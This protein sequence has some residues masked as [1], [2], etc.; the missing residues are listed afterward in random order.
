MRDVIQEMPLTHLDSKKRWVNMQTSMEMMHQM[1]DASQQS[2]PRIVD[3]A[4]Q[5]GVS[6][7]TVDRV[8]NGRPGV[9]KKTVD[10]VREAERWLAQTGGRPTVVAPPPIG[11]VLD[12]LLAGGKGFANEI[13]MHEFKKAGRA[14]G[15]D[16]RARFV[17]RASVA[18][19]R[20]ELEEC[21]KTRSDGVIVQ[22]IEHLAVRDAMLELADS[23]VPIVCALT[24][25]PGIE[26]LGYSGLD[27]R[28]AGR[29]AGLLL[30]HLCGRR[31]EVAIF[32]SD[33]LYRSHE[34][35]ESGVRNL[36]RSD[37]PD[38]AT[39][40][41]VNTM[42]NPETCYKKTLDLI[43]RHPGLAG[44]CNLGGGNR[45][46]EKAAIEAGRSQDLAYVAFNLTPLTRKSLMDGTIKGVVHQDMGKISRNAIDLIC[47]HHRGERATSGYV[48]A[49]IIMRENIRDIGYGGG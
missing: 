40:E 44:I 43:E 27:N 37:F 21:R 36:L 22:P 12:I 16:L 8:M 9:K 13:L 19:L 46:I 39:L 11:L 18:S 6:T 42:D 41:S 17:E 30:G 28:A 7:A 47:A 23:G 5:A 1:N 34:E 2:R 31:G 49:E 20:H 29:A 14:A 24:T 33:A 35:R 48:P 3:I 38:V 15:V 4:L 26:T 25:L 32:M 45:G 10:K